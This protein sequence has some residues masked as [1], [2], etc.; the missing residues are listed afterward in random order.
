MYIPSSVILSPVDSACNLGVIFLKGLSFV[1][2]TSAVAKSCFQHIICD[3]RRIRNTTDQT[4]ACTIANSLI[5]SKIEY[6]VTLFYS[7]YTYYSNESSLFILFIGQ[8]TLS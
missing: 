7:I 2:H 6:S 8:Y 1:Q 5:H 3:L 4:T